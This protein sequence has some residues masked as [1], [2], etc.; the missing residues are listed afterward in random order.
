MASNEPQSLCQHPSTHQTLP[1]NT[2]LHQTPDPHLGLCKTQ[3]SSDSANELTDPAKDSIEH[4]Q[5]V[6]I[7]ESL[8]SII[9]IAL[10]IQPFQN[11]TSA[12]IPVTL[13]RLQKV[14][15]VVNKFIG[16]GDQSEAK[17]SAMMTA[18]TGTEYVDKKM[19]FTL[20]K[21]YTG[22]QVKD[23]SMLFKIVIDRKAG[24]T[25]VTRYLTQP[26][27]RFLGLVGLKAR[28]ESDDFDQLLYMHLDQASNKIFL[29]LFVQPKNKYKYLISFGAETSALRMARY[30]RAS[31][32]HRILSFGLSA[33]RIVVIFMVQ[34]SP[35]IEW[36]NA[37]ASRCCQISIA[38]S[39]NK[40]SPQD[41]SSDPS[42]N[43]RIEGF[44]TET[45]SA[46]PNSHCGLSVV[47]TSERQLLLYL[48]ELASEEKS[49]AASSSLIGQ[50]QIDFGA[51]AQ[52]A[53]PAL[54]SGL[55]LGS[56]T[57]VGLCLLPRD[58]STLL[59]VYASYSRTGIDV[60][61][62]QSSVD[63]SNRA[64]EKE[65]LRAQSQRLPT[66]K[67]KFAD[68]A[69]HNT[70]PIDTVVS[71]FI[72]H[73][74]TFNDRDALG[75]DWMNTKIL[76]SDVK[77]VDNKICMMIS[78]SSLKIQE[79]VILEGSNLT[80]YNIKDETNQGIASVDSLQVWHSK[81]ESTLHFLTQSIT[82]QHLTV[83]DLSFDIKLKDQMS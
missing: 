73:R 51:L 52:T 81:S 71:L 34:T 35:H 54:L 63:L 24:T 75:P 23:E 22:V 28:L 69:A 70:F 62:L 19:N 8:F 79:M 31:Q 32:D 56:L 36:Y 67:K 20:K 78:S 7:H 53:S 15:S 40:S 27:S 3:P 57:L 76:V 2:L 6:N 16:I 46:S 38:S 82:D 5:P 45:V 64:R 18:Y 80:H 47:V 50:Y 44:V 25:S 48:V 83:R 9:R 21:C 42:G 17:I 65:F 43:V 4:P 37:I 26:N 74:L 13:V 14:S 49:T 59:L 55:D 60:L 41:Q 72:C 30:F 29:G 12:Y 61:I 33:T 39:T 77:A 68:R 1:K 11:S 58:P 66:F 10:V